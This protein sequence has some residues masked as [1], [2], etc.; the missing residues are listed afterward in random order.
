M[1]YAKQSE[2]QNLFTEDKFILRTVKTHQ[3]DV[4]NLMQM[5]NAGVNHVRG[6]KKDS[7]LNKIPDFH[8]TNNFAIDPMHTILE[9][10]IP[11]N[12][13]AILTKICKEK[14]IFTIN[15]LNKR[16]SYI[17][18][19]IS[20]D[21]RNKPPAIFKI[22]EKKLHPSMKAMQMWAFFRFLPLA[23]GDLV[24]EDDKHWSFFIQLCNLVDILLA[25]KFTYGMITLLRDLIE[26]HLQSFK[27]LFPD[28]KLRP[29]QHFLV[30]YPTII[31]QSGPL[32]GMSCLRYELKNSF[33]KRSAHI[34]CNFTNICYTLAYRH[35]YN[36]LLA[37]LTKQH[38]RGIPLVSKSNR[39]CVHLLPFENVLCFKYNLKSDDHVFVSYKIHIGS[40]NIRKD[41]YLVMS[42][43]KDGLPIFGKVEAFVNVE[44]SLIWL[45]VVSLMETVGFV[46][47]LFSYEVKCYSDE[48][49]EILSFD[50]LLDQHPLSGYVISCTSLN[51]IL[52]KKFIRML[53]KLF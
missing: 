32:I 7:V 19:M 53:Y 23:V 38:S 51:E 31:F 24:N 5:E 45:V 33:F 1:C 4:Q 14:K 30:H 28:L 39:V 26:E 46:D 20:T 35:Q 3:Q 8:I 9:G 34:V 29:K 18:S 17:F 44:N 52:N 25:P 50:T 48:H 2:I 43:N 47:H 6:V 15:I 36:S 41:H 27:E 11:I 21:K 22:E 12:L 40:I 16:M 10:L 13:A 42:I 49:F 37:K